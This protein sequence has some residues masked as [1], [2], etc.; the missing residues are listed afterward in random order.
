MGSQGTKILKLSHLKRLWH[1]SSSV[2]FK[3][4][5]RSHPVGLD[6]C[7]WSDP[8]STSILHVCEQGRLRRDCAARQNQQNVCAPNED[9]DQSGRMP[10]L[11]RV[12]ACAQWVAKGLWF[13][14]ADSEYS[15][16]TGRMPRLIWFSLGALSFC[17]FCPVA[18]H[19]KAGETPSRA[20]SN[21][22]VGSNGQPRVTKILK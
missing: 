8:S 9:S 3:P 11:I 13:L 19:L 18:A 6:I 14:H 16:Q 5:M 10:R 21:F 12:F 15:D 7:F 17:W 4:R 20:F 2:N 1:F 22:P